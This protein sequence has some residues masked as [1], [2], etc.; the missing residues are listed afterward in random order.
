DGS[1]AFERDQRVGR[2][3]ARAGME[4]LRKL[5]LLGRQPLLAVHRRPRR[6]GVPAAQE[7]LILRLVAASAI[8]GRHGFREYEAMMVLP[9]L[10]ALRLMALQATHALGGMS[11]HL[12]LVDNRVV[13]LG[14]AL[15]TLAGRA[16]HRS[17][18]LR[19]FD[20]R[21]L[22]VDEKAAEHKAEADDE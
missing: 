15:R 4:L 21:P 12:V 6:R 13:L 10:I 18:G 20:A 19:G 8:V 3:L 1:G 2:T 5:D 22:A 14:V 11:A 7:L 16:Y 17:V 9:L